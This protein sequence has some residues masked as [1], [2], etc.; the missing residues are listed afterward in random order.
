MSNDMV[1]KITALDIIAHIEPVMGKMLN[2]EKFAKMAMM[3]L[4]ENPSLSR[5][6]KVSFIRECVK[7]ARFGVHLDN[8]EAALVPFKGECKLMIMVGGLVKLARQ[9]GQIKSLASF[10]VREE[11][12]FEIY[13]DEHGQHF[14]HIPAPFADKEVIGVYA[15]AKLENGETEIETMSIKQLD[16]VQN[17]ARASNSPWKGAFKT[18]M[19]RK[20]VMRRLLKRLPS[21]SSLDNV[22]KDDNEHFDMT[23]TPPKAQVTSSRL[24]ESLDIE[25]EVQ[26]VKKETENDPA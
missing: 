16:D 18:E 9:S 25:S 4:A 12:P 23:P 3:A 8:K 7:A 21:T 22:L 15:V 17:T 1:K 2:K 14:K 6:S 26:E 5:A 24:R 19:Q 13:V 20:T 10:L 11:E